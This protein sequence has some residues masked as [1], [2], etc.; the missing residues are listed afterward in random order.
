MLLFFLG[1]AIARLE[2][3]DKPFFNIPNL[4]SLSISLSILDFMSSF[5][6]KGL[7]KMVFYQ[8]Y[9]NVPAC[10]VLVLFHCIDKM[11]LCISPVDQKT[12]TF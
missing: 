7:I 10:E 3:P 1:I 5:T 9:L 8:S 4:T 11:H 6:V 12:S 2:Y